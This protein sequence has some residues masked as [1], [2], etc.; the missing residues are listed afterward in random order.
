MQIRIMNIL[1]PIAVILPLLLALPVQ[2]DEFDKNGVRGETYCSPAKH[3]ARTIKAMASVKDERKDVV[4]VDM[5][6]RFLIYDDGQ[7]PDR[8]YMV[9]GDKSVDFTI[10][11]DGLV[12]DFIAKVETS[13]KDANLCIEDPARAGIADDD[14]SLYFEMGLTPFYKNNSGRHDIAELEEGTKDGRSHYKKMIPSAMRLFMP[15]TRCLHVEYMQADTPPQIFAQVG[16][17]LLPLETEYYNEGY[18]LHFNDL[19]KMKATALVIKGGPYKLA[20]VPTVKTMRRF[21]VGLPRGPQKNA[22][23]P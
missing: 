5:M 14:E 4:M 17:D 22:P 1:K 16:E 9:D 11:T 7:L 15:D 23:A 12:P 8:F 6:P 3:A 19:L 10:S 21:G 20:P 18:V 13:H 2:A